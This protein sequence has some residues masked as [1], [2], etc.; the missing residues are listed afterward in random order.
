MMD[1]IDFNILPKNLL[2]WQKDEIHSLL[3]DEFSQEN[4]FNL[5]KKFLGEDQL[6]ENWIDTGCTNNSNKTFF[7][8]LLKEVHKF[9]CTNCTEYQKERETLGS[10]LEN[11]V[12]IIA[13]A[14]ASKLGIAEAIL[15]GAV[16]CIV[17]AIFKIGKNAWCSSINIE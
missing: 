14:I 3:K 4:Y 5:A 13:T 1:N 2:S 7:S 15:S 10:T 9:F 11:I 16:T 8:T 6:L 17:I 12:K